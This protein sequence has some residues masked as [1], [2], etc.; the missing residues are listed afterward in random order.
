MLAVIRP[1]STGVSAVTGIPAPGAGKRLVIHAWGLQGDATGAIYLSTA[2]TQV[3]ASIVDV[4]F[5]VAGGGRVQ[6][7]YE[8]E[9]GLV[10]PANTAFFVVAATGNAWGNIEYSIEPT[11]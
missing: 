6:T 5:A 2:A 1:A 11:T 4:L 7:R 3:T 9:K 8:T 10:L